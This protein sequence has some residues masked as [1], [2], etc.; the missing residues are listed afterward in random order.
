LEGLDVGFLQMTELQAKV[1]AAQLRCTKLLHHQSVGNAD[2]DSVVVIDA[3][4]RRLSNNP[5]AAASVQGTADEVALNRLTED[6][7]TEARVL[8]RII[9][10]R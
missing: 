3:E 5:L 10:T 1:N 4:V 8:Q 6:V 2:V 9:T 7:I